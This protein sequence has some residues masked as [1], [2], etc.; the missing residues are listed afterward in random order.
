MN[1]EATKLM[2]RFKGKVELSEDKRTATVSYTFRGFAEAAEFDKMVKN[3]IYTFCNFKEE[4]DRMDE[5]C[6]KNGCCEDF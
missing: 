2:R 4:S 5:F 3:F 6:K 1:D